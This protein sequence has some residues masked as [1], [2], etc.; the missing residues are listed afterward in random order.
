MG[1]L[2]LGDAFEE[3]VGKDMRCEGGPGS[4]Q[5]VFAAESTL[6]DAFKDVSAC[7]PERVQP[8]IKI[9]IWSDGNMERWKYGNMAAAEQGCKSG[10]D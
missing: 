3:H 4:V 6:R 1:A 7:A 10:V 2:R 9:K 5:T 8:K